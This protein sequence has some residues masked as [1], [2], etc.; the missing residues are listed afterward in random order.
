VDLLRGLIMALMVLDHTRDFFT[1]ARFDATDLSQT[2]PAIFFTRWVTHF[3]APV[4]MFLAG[5]GASLSA[6]RGKPR[7]ELA[8]FLAT[9]GLW[10]IFLEVTVSRFG[11]FFNLDYKF[12]PFIVLWALGCSMIALS[13]L[14]FL[15]ELVIAAFGLAMIA[16][17]NLLDG[18]SAQQVGLPRWLWSMLHQPGPPP[19]E[20]A[21]GRSC[22]FLYPLIPWVGVMAVGYAFGALLRLEPLKRR[23]V[24]LSLGLATTLAFVA[25]RAT[26]LYGDPRPW[27]SQASPLFTLMSFLNCQKYP[28]SLLYLLMTLGPAIALL[29]LLDRPVGPLARPLLIL[30]RVPLFFYLLQWPAL[31][32]LAVAVAVANRQPYGWLLGGGPFGAP[33]GYGYDLPFTYLMWAVTLVLL[34]PACRWF[35]DL[36]RRRADVWLSYL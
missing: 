13:A 6:S 26:N 19:I 31:H 5:V 35:A 29:A 12:T 9:R 22:M 23:R 3:C 27:A 7:P 32:G 14:I 34:Y 36:K 8:R 21:P 2:T 1:N 11:L 10:L 28:P 15:P 30:G 24:L 25:L 16:G 17:H 4:F 33:S 18:L 20:L